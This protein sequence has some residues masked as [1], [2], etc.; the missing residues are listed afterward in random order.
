MIP[1][2]E[3]CRHSNDC[4]G[5]LLLILQDHSQWIEVVKKNEET[6]NM[7]TFINHIFQQMSMLSHFLKIVL[8]ISL[9]FAI[10]FTELKK[11][12]KLSTHSFPQTNLHIDVHLP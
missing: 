5:C 3:H 2:V 4:I 12:V 11:S 7:P 10:M 9:N 8:N 6:H 1:N